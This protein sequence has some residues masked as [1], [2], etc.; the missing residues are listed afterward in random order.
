MQGTW[1]LAWNY[2]EKALY[3]AGLDFEG[4]QHDA[5][6]DAANT[7]ELLRIVRNQHLF[8][9]HLQVAKEALETKSLGNTLGSMFEFSGLLETIA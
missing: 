6:S 3:Y 4:Q 2:Y 5:L 9:E 1:C 7:A 8:E